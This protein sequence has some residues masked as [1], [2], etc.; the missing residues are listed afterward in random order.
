MPTRNVNLTEEL[1]NFG[2]QID[3]GRYENASEVI[4]AAAANI[5]ARGTAFEAKL[6]ALRKRLISDTSGSIQEILSGVFGRPSSFPRER[7]R[8]SLFEL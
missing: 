1:D 2:W 8:T 5:R 6:A 4:R 3:S 7:A